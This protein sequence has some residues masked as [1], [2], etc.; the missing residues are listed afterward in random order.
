MKTT[1]ASPGSDP[2][3]VLDKLVEYAI[4][5]YRE[6]V[7]EFAKGNCHLTDRDRMIGYSD[8]LAYLDGL[9]GGQM[10][11]SPEQ[12]QAIRDEAEGVAK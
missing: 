10:G 8:V 3:W 7:T 11:R 9:T 5:R 1:L 4:R 6:S 12:L 2:E